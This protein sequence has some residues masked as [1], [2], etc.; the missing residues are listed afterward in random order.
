MNEVVL[1]I[2]FNHKYESNLEKLR[3]IYA[4]RFSNIYFIMPF[5]K[6]S[7]KDVI[8]VYGNSFFFQSYIA[9]AL[10]RIN[11]NRFKHYIIIGDDLLLNTSINE[12]NY[13]SEFSLKSDGGFIPEVFMLDDYKEKPR[14]M[15]GGFEKWVWNY[16]AL[17]F[18]YKNI[19]GI[20]VEKEL[21]TEE[22]ALE[23]ISSHGYSFNSLL[24]R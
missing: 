6:G 24:Y 5:Y 14:L 23:T 16:N 3:K 7:D 8:C 2:L 11:N 13:E 4:G 17:C 20:E 15:M 18:D 10:Q 21:P 22:Q 19:A 12:K 1:L 9:Q